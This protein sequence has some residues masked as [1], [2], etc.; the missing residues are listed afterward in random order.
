MVNMGNRGP[1][2]WSLSLGLSGLYTSAP[3]TVTTVATWYAMPVPG[4]TEVRNNSMLP[5][6]RRGRIT[7]RIGP[8][9]HL[10][11]KN[12][13]VWCTVRRVVVGKNC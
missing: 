6:V 3:I 10:F 13:S 7:P 2:N 4:W 12:A 9:G 8:Q 1:A 5:D 11:E